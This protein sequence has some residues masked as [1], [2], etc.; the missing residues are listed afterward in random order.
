M[1]KKKTPE[2]EIINVS[3]TALDALTSR[4]TDGLPLLDGDAK[5]LLSVLSTYKWLQRQLKSTKLTIHRLKKMFGFNTE[6]RSWL[7]KP[8]LPSDLSEQDVVNGDI[9]PNS[10]T[11]NDAELTTTKK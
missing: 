11:L 9:Q 2:I 4:L 6:K 7:K 10:T 5:I 8:T 3:E 1:K